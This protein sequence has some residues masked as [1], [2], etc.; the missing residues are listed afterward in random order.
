MRA[1]IRSLASEFPI[2]SPAH[3]LDDALRKAIDTKT[4]PIGSLGRLEELAFQI[5]QLQQ[6]LTPTIHQPEMMIFAGDHGLAKAGV[7]A[8]PQAVTLQMVLNFL[9][10]GA[11]INVFCRQHEI[12]LTIVNAGVAGE[13][14]DHPQL[15]N[16]PISEGTHSSLEGPA[17]SR[18]A[19]LQAIHL[20]ARSCRVKLD[21]GSNWIG[22]G[23]MG[24]GNTASASLLMHLL[25]G[26]PLSQC[27]G[28]GTGLDD[29]GLI[30]KQ[31][32]LQQ[33]VD[34]VPQ[35]PDAFLALQEVGGLEIAA[36][37]GGMLQ[38]ASRGAV[39]MVDGFISTAAYLVA[40]SIQPA[41]KD[42]AMF[43]H[44][45]DESGHRA[46]LNHL[47]AAPLLAL[48]LRLGEGTG[49]ALAYPLVQSACHMLNEMAS[50]EEAGVSN[51]S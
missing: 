20:G 12:G 35:Q 10:G 32:I 38:T 3:T 36:M 21:A 22:F 4:K 17:M 9:N 45:S 46:M 13:L 37:V 33:V 44:C 49:V 28:R 8:F 7:S 5:G 11:A 51:R 25:T 41:L 43:S 39:V 30:R 19:T 14:Q 34:R 24:I 27:I 42:Y 31:N 2:K 26:I 47:N 18:E 6:T 48:D 50:F 16:R 29:A 1:D 40:Q 23:E 15:V